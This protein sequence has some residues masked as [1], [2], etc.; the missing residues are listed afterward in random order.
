MSLTYNDNAAALT[1]EIINDEEDIGKFEILYN[2]KTIKGSGFKEFLS[3]ASQLSDNINV[4]YIK[5]LKWFVRISQS[6]IDYKGKDFFANG[7]KE[8][9][10]IQIADNV[11]LRN[12]DNFWSKIDDK[13]EFLKRLDICRENFKG[14][15]KNKLG[16]KNH[17][18]YTLAKEMWEDMKYRYYLWQPWAINYC[19]EMVPKTEEELINLESLDKASFYFCNSKYFNKREYYVYCYDLSSSHLSFLARK[20]FPYK[21]F[22]LEEDTKKIQNI[23]KLKRDAWYCRI[24]FKKLQYK[25]DFPINLQRFGWPEPDFGQCCWNL[26][27]TNVDMEWFKEVFSWEGAI[28]YNFYHAPQKELEKDY[29]KMFDSLYEWKN[30]QKKGTFAKEIC[31]FRAELPFGQ[32]MKKTSYCTK[33]IWTEEGFEVVEEEEKTLEEIQKKIVKR[34]IPMQVSYWVAAYSRLEEFTIINRIGIDNVLYGDTDSVKFIG[35]E[36]IQVIEE[37]NSEIEKEFNSINSKRFLKFNQKLGKWCDEGIMACFKAIGIKWY[38]TIDMDGHYDV[39]AAGADLKKLKENLQE[40]NDPVTAFNLR[41]K[42]DGLFKEIAPSRKKKNAI[43]FR[44]KNKMDNEI[45]K[46]VLKYQGT[47]LY[48]YNP[49][50]KGG[51]L[52]DRYGNG[53]S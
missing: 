21:G 41:M 44:Y 28:V 30:Q 12:W 9:Y 40:R 16:L 45:K 48:Y 4:I 23:I 35:K 10:F 14:N 18:K 47:D 7:E 53:L 38:I 37:R 36:G 17:Y 34:G 19:K 39:K 25:I 3:A 43:V 27:L 11:E 33:T 15:Y 22:E 6:F 42:V 26:A 50:G 1:W 31:K 49:Y 46:E 20:R 24:I 5:Y 29:A 32:P 13:E 51:D 2:G 52:N 8:F